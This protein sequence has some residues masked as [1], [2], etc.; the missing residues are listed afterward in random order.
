M[1]ANRPVF[2]ETLMGTTLMLSLVLSRSVSSD[3]EVCATLEVT[4][5]Y[6]EVSVEK[7]HKRTELIEE[8]CDFQRTL[9]QLELAGGINFG[10]EGI[11]ALQAQGAY[12]KLTE[13]EESVNREFRI[14]NDE[15]VTFQPGFSQIMKDTT[16]IMTVD[17]YPG[18][19]KES[20]YLD[21]RYVGEGGAESRNIK[22][23]LPKEVAELQEMANREIISIYGESN[24]TIRQGT[25]TEKL[26]LES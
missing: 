15:E 23:V 26:C 6:R 1:R 2:A 24:G 9:D 21:S 16:T 11:F 13:N 12:D 5:E 7:H 8:A 20:E 4:V 14:T 25:Y 3:R 22:V 10:I 17:G 18:M 19:V